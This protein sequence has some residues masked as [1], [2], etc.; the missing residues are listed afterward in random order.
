MN[1]AQ[2]DNDN[3]LG[4]SP[5]STEIPSPTTT[6]EP[7]A[8]GFRRLRKSS[9]APKATK[10]LKMPR[11]SRRKRGNIIVS[12]AVVVV[13]AAV[14]YWFFVARATPLKI[15][16]IE[17]T[18]AL[19]SRVEDAEVKNA[20]KEKE[21]I[22]LHFKYSGAKVG[23]IVDFTVKDKDKKVVLSG[24]TTVLRPTG[25]D[26]ADG[27]RYISIV[28]SGLQTLATGKYTATLTVNNRTVKTIT[29]T[30]K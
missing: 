23:M 13:I 14:A 27:Q 20:F 1:L 11:K 18:N 21:P 10:T 29:F 17:T 22:M 12:V 5:R 3:T 30:V 16:K 15:T 6:P 2:R 26:T 19:S 28:N 9:R 4:E 25:A 8:K 24:S 7:S